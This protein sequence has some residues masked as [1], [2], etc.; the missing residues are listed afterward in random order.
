MNATTRQFAGAVLA[1]CVLAL[2]GC[3][4]TRAPGP[5][6]ARVA[7]T[8]TPPAQGTLAY[9]KSIFNALFRDHAK[10]RREVREIDRGIEATTE[11]DDPAVAA[12][13]LDHV[14]AMKGRLET[15]RRVRQWDPLYV[16]MFDH[17]AKVELEIIATP[18]GVRVRETST[19]PKVVALIKAHAKVV[20]AFASV[21]PE[22]AGREHPVPDEAL[23]DSPSSSI[24]SSP[25]R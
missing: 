5:D 17:G 10:I 22:E 3:A 25:S 2:G 24:P 9:D 16:A 19:D 21:G 1:G 11:S 7:E 8:T 15:G 13:L 23:S 20:S 12:R 6:A 18:K 4:T 14:T